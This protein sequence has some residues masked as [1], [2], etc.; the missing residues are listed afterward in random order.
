ME[1][2]VVVWSNY[3]KNGNDLVLCEPISKEKAEH[4]CNELTKNVGNHFAVR[5]I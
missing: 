5:A 2:Y 4:A 3:Y 1:K